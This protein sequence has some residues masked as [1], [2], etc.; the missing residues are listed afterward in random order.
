MLRMLSE[1]FQDVDIRQL[2]LLSDEIDGQYDAVTI[3]RFIRHYEYGTRRVLWAKLRQLIGEN[4]VV[5]FDVPNARFEIPHRQSNGWGQYQ[6][7]DIFWT[8]HAL[9]KELND[10]GLRLAALIPIGQG[11]YPMPAEFRGEP[12]TWTAAAIRMP[13]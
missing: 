5:L 12:M 11:L 10:N 7:Y 8:R 13:E 6:I 1:Q 4:G 2:D 9:E 3:F